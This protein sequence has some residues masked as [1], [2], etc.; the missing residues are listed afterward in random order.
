M[1]KL[2]LVRHGNTTGNS[3]LRFWGSTDVELSIEGIGQAERLRDRL[4]GEKIDHIYASPLSRARRTAEL[5]AAGHN[6]EIRD[7]ADL[8][9]IDFGKLEGLTY[10][11]I[12]SQYPDMAEAL[13]KWNPR[14]DFPGGE[15]LDDMDG[16][17]RR[18]IQGLDGHQSEETVLIVS[19][20][21]TLRLMICNLLG[22]GLEHWRHMQM[23]LASMSVLDTYPQGAILRSLN[24][25]SH[26]K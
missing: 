12:V 15:S 6:L 18:F 4:T 22:I 17:V 21:G 19:H 23:D 20:A 7:A 14:P 13:A 8:R 1:A 11:E 25:T 5:I 10:E 26:L 16:R 24:D 2:I 3:A 9:E